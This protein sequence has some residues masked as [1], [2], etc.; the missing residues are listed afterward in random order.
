MLERK[1][2]LVSSSYAGHSMAQSVLVQLH[3]DVGHSFK[4]DVYKSAKM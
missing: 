3:K 1:Q 2:S 4:V